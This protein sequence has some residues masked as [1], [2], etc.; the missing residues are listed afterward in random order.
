MA[1]KKSVPRRQ[2]AQVKREK[3]F[4]DMPKEKFIK[5]C[6]IA[7]VVIVLVVAVFL[8]KPLW[9][10]RLPVQDGMVATEAD[11]WLIVNKGTPQRPA[12]HK[13]GSVGDVE[14]YT[15]AKDTSMVTD[16]NTAGQAFTP[17]DENSKIKGAHV[18]TG[19]GAY[20]ELAANMQGNFARFFANCTTTEVE[21]L[22]LEGKKAKR[23][24]YSYSV[25]NQPETD[26]AGNALPATTTYERGEY[27]YIKA[28]KG[29]CIFLW[30]TSSG[31]EEAALATQEEISAEALKIASAVTVD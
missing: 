27:V 28:G 26:E 14:G 1:K 22:D 24:G 23:I 20:D 7:A 4:I 25:E 10:G 9:D 18:M 16:A 2:Q 30:V 21:D 5:I 6:I 8:T 13:L 19:N 29:R 3:K 31:P 12:Y 17:S 15:R 11:N